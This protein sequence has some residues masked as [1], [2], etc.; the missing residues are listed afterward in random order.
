[1]AR[2]KKSRGRR[3]KKIPLATVIGVG[4]TAKR[5]YDKWTLYDN[6]TDR[7]KRND[8][9]IYHMTGIATKDA[10]AAGFETDLVGELSATWGPAVAGALI[11]TYVGG[12]KGL[13]LNA[14]L[15][16]VPLVKL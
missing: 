6:D 12:P 15:S 16:G 14:K 4:L 2:R 11:S 7:P 9:M 1:M 8:Y 3:N 5:L 10:Q 13:N